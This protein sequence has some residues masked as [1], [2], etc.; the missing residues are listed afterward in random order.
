MIEHRNVVGW[1]MSSMT[2]MLT[3]QLRA[4]EI[5]ADRPNEAR[6]SEPLPQRT[7]AMIPAGADTYTAFLQGRGLGAAGVGLVDG[8]PSSAGGNEASGGLRLW[9]HFLDRV[10]A[11]GE[12]GNNSKGKF[13]P[14][15]AVAVRALG[16]RKRGLAGG[17]LARYR[18]EGFSTIEG[19]IEGGLIGSYATHHLH[20]DTGLI[21]GVGIE[22]E[23]AD[24]ELLLR[25]GYD[26]APIFRLG[27]ETRI[28]REL[29]E[30]EAAEATGVEGGEWDAFAG[31]QGT[32]AIDHFFA[33]LTAGV[34]KPRFTANVGWLAHV[35][36][37]AVAF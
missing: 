33:S 32:L 18:T 36:V 16:D 29:A 26:L 11:Q 6:Q 17:V 34:Q 3:P 25:L 7:M 27:L 22:E 37:G 4:Q 1:L 19:E 30:E 5:A 8:R 31:P 10:V 9:G 12:V 15:V 35:M 28:R 20:L 21:A 24:G 23:E 14:S 13:V 2:L